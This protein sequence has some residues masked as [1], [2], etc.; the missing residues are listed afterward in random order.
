MSIPYFENITA[1]SA[2]FLLTVAIQNNIL[3]SE[4]FVMD[5]KDRIYQQRKK[6]D[7]TLEDV[8][9][10]VGVTRGT[11]QQWESG[12]IA[13]ARHDKIVKLASVL[14]CSPAYLMG[15]EDEPYSQT[16]LTR[17]FV[18]KAINKALGDKPLSE[19]GTRILFALV[20]ALSE[21]KQ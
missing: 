9:Q 17:E 12:R 21:H 11:V 6:L 10:A 3:C 7:L 18:M 19:E 14:D 20:E 15:W 8:A 4:V 13:N 2:I 5:M 1:I 16:P